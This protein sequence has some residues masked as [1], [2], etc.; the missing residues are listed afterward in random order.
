MSELAAT[1]VQAPDLWQSIPLE[2]I[3]SALAVLLAGALKFA[4]ILA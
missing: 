3:L 1:K 2:L 4:G